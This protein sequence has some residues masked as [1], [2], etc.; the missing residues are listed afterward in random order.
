MIDRLLYRTNSAAKRAGKRSNQKRERESCCDVSIEHKDKPLQPV[1]GS[2]SFFSFRCRMQMIATSDRHVKSRQ[3]VSTLIRKES[4]SAFV[5]FALSPCLQPTRCNK[6]WLVRWSPFL[7]QYDD[8][9]DGRK[10]TRSQP[11]FQI[12]CLD[13]DIRLLFLFFFSPSFFFSFFLSSTFCLVLSAGI[14]VVKSKCA[15]AGTL[16]AHCP[17]VI[18]Y[19]DHLPSLCSLR[20]PFKSGSI[21]VRCFLNPD[22]SKQYQIMNAKNAFKTFFR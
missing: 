22:F 5:R 1:S 21:F 11:I 2:R 8:V 12:L 18:V 9:D 4:C 7:P 14:F 19:T 10:R 13:F 3:V 16:S 20:L 17:S 15:L 6:S